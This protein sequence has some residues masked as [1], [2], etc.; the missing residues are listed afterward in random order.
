MTWLKQGEGE[1]GEGLGKDTGFRA[2][3]GMAREIDDRGN[4]GGMV[5]SP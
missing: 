5:L 4:L 3:K 2:G 1:K